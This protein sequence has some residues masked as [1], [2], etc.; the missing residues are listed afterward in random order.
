M[1]LSASPRKVVPLSGGNDWSTP[2]TMAAPSVTKRVF[3]CGVV[4]ENISTRQAYSQG[5]LQRIVITSV[6]TPYPASDI[7]ELVASLGEPL[8]SSDVNS[9]A[10]DEFGNEPDSVTIHPLSCVDLG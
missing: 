3:F 9:Q 6:Q 2:A 8:Q 1:A 7:Q 5:T 4:M 10:E